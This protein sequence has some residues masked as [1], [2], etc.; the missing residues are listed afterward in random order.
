MGKLFTLDEWIIIP[1]GDKKTVFG[2]EVGT[3]NY[4]LTSEIC[5]MDK[6]TPPQ[7]AMTKSGSRYYLLDK[8]ASISKFAYVAAF[9]TLLQWG[10]TADQATHYLN[11]ADAALKDGASGS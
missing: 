7:W 5:E 4:R 1:I 11:M 8:A 2:R 6:Y 10:F 3:T 9:D